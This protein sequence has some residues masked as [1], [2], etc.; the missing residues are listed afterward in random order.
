MPN[1]PESN[2]PNPAAY[3]TTVQDTVCDTVTRLRWQ[4]RVRGSDPVEWNTASTYCEG[5]FAG[6]DWRLPTRIELV[7]LLD[8]RKTSGINED[9]FLVANGCFWT[10]SASTLSNSKWAVVFAEH[11]AVKLL[12]RENKCSVRCIAA[13]ASETIAE[14]NEDRYSLNGDIVHDTKTTLD[15]H[16]LKEHNTELPLLKT[17]A[18]ASPACTHEAVSV[19]DM[20]SITGWRLPTMKELQTLVDEEQS[21]GPLIESDTFPE[22]QLNQFWT[23]TDDIPSTADLQPSGAYVVNFADGSA[24][25]RADPTATERH[26]IRCVR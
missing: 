13:A 14:A 7:S 17:I 26:H 1:S 2:L 4:K 8:F 9:D 15:W 6:Y 25:W 10:S 20:G 12:D 5:H 16:L 24:T 11:G 18:L 22:M 23:S 19:K 21:T 3:D